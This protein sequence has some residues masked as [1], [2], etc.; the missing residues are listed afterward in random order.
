MT[1]IFSFRINA[2][3]EFFTL[4][5]FGADGRKKEGNE[6]F[7]VAGTSSN[8]L[9]RFPRHTSVRNQHFSSFLFSPSRI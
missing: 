7:L 9:Q 3:K 1:G 2:L 4:K 6:R 5:V 8:K